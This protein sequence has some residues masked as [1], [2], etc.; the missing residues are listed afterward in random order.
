MPLLSD[1][2]KERKRTTIRNVMGVEGQHLSLI[3]RPKAR[4]TKM[5]MA[6]M[7]LSRLAKENVTDSDIESAADALGV[8]VTFLA[9]AILD[10]D[11]EHENG[12]T[13]AITEETLGDLPL[14]LLMDLV[15]AVSGDSG[16]LTE[17][18]KLSNGNFAAISPQKE[19]SE[20]FPTGMLPSSSLEPP[21]RSM[22]V[23][24]RGNS[25]SE[26]ITG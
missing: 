15:T 17:E 25:G 3:Y 18:K 4:S 13:V 9:D 22:A 8:V 14:E 12:S 1:L 24:R 6:S 19:S 7:Q 20:V 11:L 23:S 5:V 2:L 16:E 21:A 26:N 10:W